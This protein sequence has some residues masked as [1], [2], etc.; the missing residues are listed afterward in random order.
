MSLSNTKKYTIRDLRRDF[1]NEDACL[2]H[3]FKIYYGE[4][5][6]CPKCTKKGFYRVKG[7]KAYAC[8][9]CGYHI[10]PTA[11]TIFHKS[12]TSLMDW[13]FAIY[14]T[15]QSKHE[16]SAKELQRYIGCNYKTALRMLKKIKKL[17]KNTS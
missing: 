13:F 10:H 4:D 12:S 11:N 6:K 14:L 15:S 3:L 7:R 16:I 1:P 5:C 2:D 8:A 17:D 9:W